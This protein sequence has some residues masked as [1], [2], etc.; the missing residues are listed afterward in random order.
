M[1]SLYVPEKQEK[2]ESFFTR[3][4]LEEMFVAQAHCVSRYYIFLG[5]RIQRGFDQ[6]KPA[7]DWLDPKSCYWSLRHFYHGHGF[8]TLAWIWSAFGVSVWCW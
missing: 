8:G 3:T 7:K 2:V 4:S 6:R 5:F 1:F